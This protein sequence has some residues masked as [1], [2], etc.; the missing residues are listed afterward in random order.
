M[1]PVLLLFLL[2]LL[3]L[4]GDALQQGIDFVLRK[5]LL[6]HREL[7]RMPAVAGFLSVIGR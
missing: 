6:V 3:A 5:D 7:P 4:A 1:P 2:E